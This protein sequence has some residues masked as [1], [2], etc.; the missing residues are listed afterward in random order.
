MVA[1]GLPLV[2]ELRAQLLHLPR[3]LLLP[4]RRR[5]QLAR[6][7]LVLLAQLPHQVRTLT[8]LLPGAG[9]RLRQAEVGDRF[10]EISSK[11]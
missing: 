2:L 6:Q 4:P 10:N 5:L 11:Y 1:H 3:Q 9:L 7:P 8:V